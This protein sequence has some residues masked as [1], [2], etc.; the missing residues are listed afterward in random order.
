MTWVN[1]L[2]LFIAFVRVGLLGYGG[3][4]S[5]IPLVQI[6]AVRN[7][8]WC[9]KDEFVDILA[10]GNAL[11]GPIATKMAGYIGYK[12]AGVPGVVS[13]ELGLIGPSLVAMV[14][15]FI[16]LE[17]FKNSPYVGGMIKAVKPVVI[18]LL[19][20]LI[21]DMWPSSM[22]KWV[23]GVIAVVAFALVQVVK[24]HPAI[25]VVATLAFGAFA[26]R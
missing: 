21:I 13:A 12:V 22:G 2:R 5:S 24:I 20:Q 26:L 16:G 7:Y 17:H 11:P 18:I 15:L 6:E 3:G 19:L 23:Y 14:L 25:V 8:A 10:M 1:L 9:T 4:P